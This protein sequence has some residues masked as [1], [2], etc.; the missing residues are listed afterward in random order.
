MLLFA[1]AKLS[2]FSLPIKVDSKGRPKLG[3]TFKGVSSDAVRKML[4]STFWTCTVDLDTEM[5]DS[6]R[7]AAQKKLTRCGMLLSCAVLHELVDQVVDYGTVCNQLASLF[8]VNKNR[9]RK[10]PV[11][12]DRITAILEP[13]LRWCEPIEED[14]PIGD[15]VKYV[16]FPG[17]SHYILKAEIHSFNAKV[18]IRYKESDSASSY[19]SFDL[20][21]RHIGELAFRLRNIDVFSPDSSGP[22]VDIEFEK[23]IHRPHM[24]RCY[25]ACMNYITFANVMKEIPVKF[26]D[27]PSVK[28]IKSHRDAWQLIWAQLKLLITNKKARIQEDTDT[29]VPSDVS[30]ANLIQDIPVVAQLHVVMDTSDAD[31]ESLMTLPDSTT[32][33]NEMDGDNPHAATLFDNDVLHREAADRQFGFDE[34]AQMDMVDENY[35]EHGRSQSFLRTN[36]IFLPEG[37]DDLMS[38]DDRIPGVDVHEGQNTFRTEVEL[39]VNI[40]DE[41]REVSTFPQVDNYSGEKS[42][43]R[44]VPSTITPFQEEIISFLQSF[45]SKEKGEFYGSSLDGTVNLVLGGFDSVDAFIVPFVHLLQRGILGA[46]FES[47]VAK[48]IENALRDPATLFYLFMPKKIVFDPPGDGHCWFHTAFYLRNRYRAIKA[49]MER[50]QITTM[51][52]YNELVSSLS[53]GKKSELFNNNRTHYKKWIDDEIGYLTKHLPEWN[54]TRK[55]GYSDAG[56][57][58]DYLVHFKRY[59]D[60]P[61]LSVPIEQMF[62]NMYLPHIFGEETQKFPLISFELDENKT[63][64]Q[65]KHHPFTFDNYMLLSKS[66]FHLFLNDSMNDG[67]QHHQHALQPFDLFDFVLG[68]MHSSAMGIETHSIHYKVVGIPPPSN[69][70]M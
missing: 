14:E 45:F 30:P 51:S 32:L 50:D 15:E 16:E 68:S 41:A 37:D 29:E 69:N 20:L 64:A 31:R 49:A 13:V 66:N 11:D 9:R 57:L 47:T 56:Y 70:T 38:N 46:G 35:Q 34:S 2:Y 17:C 67:L 40:D 28:V 55:R 54:E 19:I 22:G 1:L 24:R 48:Q 62:D 58:I 5:S 52:A 44:S 21:A 18:P 36:S 25:K 7:S 23:S 4:Y 10:A 12:V 59:I 53:M 27:H 33:H 26:H 39:T 8:E 65:V 60:D 3:V 6:K 61:T 43:K 42:A 63:M